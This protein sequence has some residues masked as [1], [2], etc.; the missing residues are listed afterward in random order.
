MVIRTNVQSQEGPHGGED[1]EPRTAAVQGLR[2]LEVGPPCQSQ[3]QSQGQAW[4]QKFLAKEQMTQ[5][6]PLHTW[7]EAELHLVYGMLKAGVAGRG[8][9][10]LIGQWP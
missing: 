5:V 10:T 6:Q 8:D 2:S 3:S 9:N 1:G 7:K 4:S